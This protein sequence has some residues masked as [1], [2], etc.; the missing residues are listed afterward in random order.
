MP[1]R[2]SDIPMSVPF[3]FRNKQPFPPLLEIE[4]RGYL[5]RKQNKRTCA[6]AHRLTQDSSLESLRELYEQDLAEPE[7]GIRERLSLSL[8]LSV[9]VIYPGRG[10]Q[11][12]I[13]GGLASERECC[14]LVLNSETSTPQWIR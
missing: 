5:P 3:T 7:L 11:A 9:C 14:L 10:T 12:S 1:L 8:F 2:D 6:Q 13:E 4:H